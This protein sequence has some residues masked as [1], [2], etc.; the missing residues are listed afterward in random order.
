M[1]GAPG[2]RKCLSKRSFTIRIRKLPG[3]TISSAT[4]TVN[5]KRVAVRSGKRLTAPVNLRKLPKEPTGALD[6]AASEQL[7]AM[8]G[9]LA[10]EVG[11]TV[12]LVSHEPEA[13]RHVDRVLEMLDGHLVRDARVSP[14]LGPAAG[15]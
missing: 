13:Q 14:A 15:A 3:I 7:L 11:I 6:S 4:V 10:R 2:T 1:S 8:L 12:L 9:R 5:G